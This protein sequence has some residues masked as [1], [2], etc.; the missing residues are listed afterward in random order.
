MEEVKLKNNQFGGVKGCSSSHL[1]ISVWQRVLTDLEDCRA[2]TVLTA[3]DYA[4][5]F[6]R[7]DFK[8][9]LNA[10]AR[11]GA[12]NQVLRLIATF[13]HERTM[14][15]RVGSTWSVPR[16]VNGGVPQGSILGVLLFNTTTDNLEDDHDLVEPPDTCLLY[17]SP[18]PRDR[19]K[20][21]MPSSA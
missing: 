2:A 16:M 10:F 19:Q 1:L 6:N 12:S 5:A 17:T 7:M 14:S 3:V 15:V 8:E 18:S 20:S 11:H 13:L 21:R 9:C 4:K